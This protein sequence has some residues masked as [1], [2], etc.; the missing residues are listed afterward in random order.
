MR[1]ATEIARIVSIADTA[2]PMSQR[3]FRDTLTQQHISCRPSAFKGMG[4]R[5]EGI[6]GAFFWSS[7]LSPRP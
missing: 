6:F 1:A 2:E 5:A 3:R 4:Q 7:A